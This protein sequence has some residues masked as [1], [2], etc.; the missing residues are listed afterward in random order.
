MVERRCIIVGIND[1]KII[2]RDEFVN[3][4][5]TFKPGDKIDLHIIRENGPEI[6]IIIF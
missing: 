6:M 4:M 2:K 3:E 1:K 5:N